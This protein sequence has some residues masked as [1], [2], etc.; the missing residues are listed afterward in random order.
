MRIME[1]NHS[2]IVHV[3][4]WCPDKEECTKRAESEGKT[5]SHGVCEECAKKHFE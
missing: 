1:N 4:A 3:C 5:V 2:N